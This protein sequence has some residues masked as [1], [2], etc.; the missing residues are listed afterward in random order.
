MAESIV[1]DKDQAELKAF[2]RSIEP[3]TLLAFATGAR[4]I[5]A[6]GLR[7]HGKILFLHNSEQLIQAGTCS[8]ELILPVNEKLLVY[9]YFAVRLA[10]G[11]QAGHKRFFRC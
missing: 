4:N 5:P 6:K 2:I 1:V 9:N 11:L 3:S 8:N 7:P 10:T